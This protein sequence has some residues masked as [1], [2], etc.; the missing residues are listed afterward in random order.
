MDVKLVKHNGS[1]KINING[2]MFVPLSFKSFRPTERNIS[3]FY[4]AGVRLFSVLTSGLNSMLG[5]PYSLYGESWI[6]EEQY[7]FTVIDNQ[8][9]LFIQN[10]PEAY[11]ALM[12]QVDTRPW[13]LE[14]N[15]GSADSFH[16]LSQAIGDNKWKDLSAKYLQTVIS[17]VE[18]K[19]GER[20][21]GYF[22][23]GG[24][25]TEWFSENDS[26]EVHP[27]KEQEY[28]RYR[29]DPN[30][31][32]ASAEVREQCSAGTFRHPVK[33]ASAIDYW[34]FNNEIV[35]D[36]ILYFAAKAQEI[37]S[38]KKLV[39]VYFGYLLELSGEWL[40]N[41]GHM[42]YE[43]V[44]LSDEIDM[45]SSPSSYEH[46]AHEDTS[47]FMV[48]YDTLAKHNKL[49]YL[50]FD[51]ITHLAPQY[52]ENFP[53]PGYD[54]KFQNEQQTIDVMRRDFMLCV[55]KGAALWWF[56][57]LEG[58]FYSK[59]MMQEISNMIQISKHLSDVSMESV[60]QIAVF[61][62]AESL[63]Y[64]DKS[65]NINTYALGYQ[66]EGLARLGA[67]YDFYSMCDIGT[68]DYEKYK[69][70]IF[71]DSFKLSPETKTII[72]EKIKTNG[73]TVLW[74]Y[75][76]GYVQGNDI[77]AQALS[78]TVGMNIKT[79]QSDE[80]CTIAYDG[81]EDGPKNVNYGFGKPLKTQFWIDDDE[82][83][84]WGRYQGNGKPALGYKRFENFTS[85]YSAGGNIPDC[86]LRDIATFAGV[87]IYNDNDVVFVNQN[88]IGVYSNTDGEVCI[89]FDEKTELKE[90]FEGKK[91]ITN[92]GC[93]KYN[94]TKGDAK[95]FL[96]LM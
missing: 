19:Y 4:K 96:K 29:N 50:E 74:I 82:A 15:P 67:P 21:Y 73:N 37:L 5:I 61:A 81:C 58:W 93:L 46:R 57:M 66:R 53:I 56:D 76:A 62:E 86:I 38:H 90:L 30:I 24:R 2:E 44:F 1:L 6:D 64:V 51:H 59:G 25:T 9:D 52:V 3:D 23:L 70:Y 33:D 11:F 14:N 18:E 83:V 10:A 89:R 47:A 12:L 77:S 71:L 55:A 26:A 43:K 22:L 78:D 35:A 28:K 20:F 60:S 75:G 54:S 32:I 45:I 36:T 95:L 31:T 65:A 91:Y 87:H 85:F 88:L 49:Y 94:A 48:T 79:L 7:D 63:F 84:V 40:W 41:S 16:S 27:Y 72:E 8:I 68:I 42:E 39:G 69:L 17:H 34:R 13:Y 80:V 92:N